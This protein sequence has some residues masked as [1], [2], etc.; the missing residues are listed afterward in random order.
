MR[1]SKTSWLRS[2]QEEL[3]KLAAELRKEA[4]EY[5]KRK[6]IKCAELIRGSVGLTLLKRKLG[7]M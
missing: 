2:M 7:R 1:T 5:E 6:L 3:R 4:D